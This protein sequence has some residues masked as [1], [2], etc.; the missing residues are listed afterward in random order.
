M[1][2]LET[3]PKVNAYMAVN[4]T[5]LDGSLL[6]RVM[7]ETFTKPINPQ[8]VHFHPGDTIALKLATIEQPMFEF[9]KEFANQ[10]NSAGGVLSAQKNLKGNVNGAIGYW[11]GYG[12]DIRE[13]I[14]E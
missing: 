8:D 7:V 3:Y 11:A 12:I 5:T 6:D 9:W 13:L 4:F 14:C 10:I 1:S 2:A